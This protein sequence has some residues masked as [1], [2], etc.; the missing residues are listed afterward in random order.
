MSAMLMQI[1]TD[2]YNANAKTS[3]YFSLQSLVQLKY[4]T[5]CQRFILT[6]DIYQQ[7]KKPITSEA[8]ELHIPATQHT[9]TAPH[10]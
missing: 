8:L 1:H 7:Y 3:I 6:R 10:L 5:K 4:D 2:I 9:C